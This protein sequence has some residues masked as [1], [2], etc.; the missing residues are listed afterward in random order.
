MY[1]PSISS[2]WFSSTFFFTLLIYKM[3]F[4]F[5]SLLQSSSTRIYSV[6]CM[7][8]PSYDTSNLLRWVIYFLI[9]QLIISSQT[10]QNL[11]A[12]LLLCMAVNN[13]VK[14]YWFIYSVTLYCV[15]YKLFYILL[16]QNCHKNVK[17]FMN[18]DQLFCHIYL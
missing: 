1:D 9:L 13:F 18:I 17:F 5:S 10:I 6:S 7:Y 14:W 11:R 4:R 3:S 15:A 2:N 16:N 8:Q 12:H